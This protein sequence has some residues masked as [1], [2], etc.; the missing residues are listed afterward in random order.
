MKAKF[1]N[2]A[3]INTSL[4][5]YLEWGGGNK[6]FL[7]QGEIEI[8]SK[9]FTDP[10]SVIHP[11][12]L[13]PLFGQIILLVTIFQRRPGK[14]LTMIGLWSLAT[15]LLFMFVIGMLSLNWKIIVSTIPFI[16]MGVLTILHRKG[17]RA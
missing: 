2:V 9:L 4:I 16:V 6:M 11:F 5:G 7:F 17:E 13:L 10:A 3:L 15:L 8:I 12:I 1:L 14:M